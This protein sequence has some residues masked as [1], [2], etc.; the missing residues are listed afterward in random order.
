MVASVFNS[1]YHPSR[2]LV[3]KRYKKAERML[4]EH[5]VQRQIQVDA[6][7]VSDDIEFD[8]NKNKR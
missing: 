4:D 7:V 1:N 5:E 8:Q 3:R 6:G 2:L